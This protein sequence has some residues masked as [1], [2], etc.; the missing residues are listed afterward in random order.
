GIRYFHVTGVQTCALP[1]SGAVRSGGPRPDR[2]GGRDVSRATLGSYMIGV[3]PGPPSEG[4]R[5]PRFA[6]GVVDIDQLR[7]TLD[8]DAWRAEIG[9][10][11]GRHRVEEV[12]DAL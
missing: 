9:R 5:M 12:R 11:S 3:T 10:A 4:V 1:M 6:S 2:G 8:L 7:G